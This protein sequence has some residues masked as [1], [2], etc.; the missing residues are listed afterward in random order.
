MEDV[1]NSG[2]LDSFFFCCAISLLFEIQDGT[3]KSV[4]AER[5]TGLMV[6]WSHHEKRACCERLVASNI[7]A[8]SNGEGPPAIQRQKRHTARDNA[9]GGVVVAVSNKTRCSERETRAP[10]KSKK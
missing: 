8:G 4:K 10:V 2:L 1:S 5:K 3:T 9:S 7:N 6:V